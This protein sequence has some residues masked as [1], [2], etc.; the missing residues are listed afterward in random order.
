MI[1][2]KCNIHPWMKAYAGVVSHSYFTVT[3]DDGSF[4]LK[5]LPPGDYTI[6]VW[7]EKYG[8]QEQQVT[9]APQESQEIEFGFEG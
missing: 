9:V 7:H 4:E 1:P 6:Q 5:D 8:T 2:I 3:G